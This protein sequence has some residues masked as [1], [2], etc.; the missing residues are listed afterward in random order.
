MQEPCFFTCF[1]FHFFT[2]LVVLV[3]F[4]CFNSHFFTSLPIITTQYKTRK[5]SRC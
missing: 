4:A 5:L 2:T 3:L 1:A